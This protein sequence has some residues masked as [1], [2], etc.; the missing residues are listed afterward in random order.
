MTFKKSDYCRELPSHFKSS[1]H[2]LECFFWSFFSF[3]ALTAKTDTPFQFTS[4][5]FREHFLLP[6]ILNQFHRYTVSQTEQSVFSFDDSPTGILISP[7]P[8]VVSTWLNTETCFCPATPGS[9]SSDDKMIQM[10]YCW[11]H[12]SAVR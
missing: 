10:Y 4:Y 5:C 6:I 9:L 7:I 12:R 3:H 1:T 2:W 11:I 8:P